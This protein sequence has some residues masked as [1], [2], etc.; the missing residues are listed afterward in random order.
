[1][2][3]SGPRNAISEA[4]GHAAADGGRLRLGLAIGDRAELQ[5]L[6]LDQSAS[7]PARGIRGR[8]AASARPPPRRAPRRADGGWRAPARRRAQAPRRSPPRGLTRLGVGRVKVPVLSN[9]TVST[10]ASRSSA[11]P[12][13]SMHA[14]TEQRPGRDHL[15]RRHR[16]AECAGTSDDQHRDRDFQRAGER[17]PGEKPSEECGRATRR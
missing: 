13:L 12:L 1:M 4:S 14:A 15:H 7:R 16:E 11:S 10:S 6:A 8:R 2:A 5:P 9:T 17:G 3:R